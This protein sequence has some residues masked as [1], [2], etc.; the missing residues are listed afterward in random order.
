MRSFHTKM[1]LGSRQD[2]PVAVNGNLRFKLGRRIGNVKEPYR[3][4]WVFLKSEIR[5]SRNLFSLYIIY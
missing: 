5:L 2:F 4:N 1:R 3:S